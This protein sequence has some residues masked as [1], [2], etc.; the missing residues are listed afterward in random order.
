MLSYPQFVRFVKQVCALSVRRT[1]LENL[2]LLTY[3]LLRGRSCCLSRIARFCPVP[4]A[5]THRLRRLWR[6]L[7]NPDFLPEQLYPQLIRALAPCWPTTLPLPLAL[8][9]TSAGGY[10]LLVAALPWRGRA[11]PLWAQACQGRWQGLLRT[12]LEEALIAA[13]VS[14]LRA[15]RKLVCGDDPGEPAADAGLL[16]QKDAHRGGLSGLEAAAGAAAGG[17]EHRG[18]DGA[19]DGGVSAGDAGLGLAGVVWG[20]SG[21]SSGRVG[22]GEGELAMVSLAAGGASQA[23]GAGA[24]A[25]AG[26]KPRRLAMIQKV[27]RRQGSGVLTSPKNLL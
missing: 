8:D 20:T 21:I 6:F 22:A 14:A 1:R 25:A 23:A 13:V 16:P 12:H 15:V 17:G 11:V 3:G 9:W 19:P 5:H 26:C 27:E 24:G 4:T 18:A 2:Q 10:E 7:R